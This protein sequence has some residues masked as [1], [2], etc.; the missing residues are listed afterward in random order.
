MRIFY[1]LLCLGS[2]VAFA[3]GSILLPLL[4]F[5]LAWVCLLPERFHTFQFTTCCTRVC[6]FVLVGPHFTPDSALSLPA[7]FLSCLLAHHIRFGTRFCRVPLPFSRCC[8][9]SVFTSRGIFLPPAALLFIHFG[10]FVYLLLLR[11]LYAFVAF[12]PHIL[13]RVHSA[14]TR[15]LRFLPAAVAPVAASFPAHLWVL[16]PLRLLRV[17]PSAS[18]QLPLSAAT[19]AHLVHCLPC[20][21]GLPCLAYLLI[22]AL[23]LPAILQ[24]HPVF[25]IPCSACTFLSY[26]SAWDF[27]PPFVSLGSDAS[28][29]CF[30][31]RLFAFSLWFRALFGFASAT[32]P[33][34]PSGFILLRDVRGLFTLSS[35]LPALR[36]RRYPPPNA[37]TL[38]LTHMPAFIAFS[39]GLLFNAL[40][41]RGSP[42]Y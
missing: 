29:I 19:H 3:L 35:C 23:P 16:P 17:L 30:V 7:G 5:F 9:H 18:R 8:R 42:A 40:V 21:T 11:I 14:W 2:A 20:Y 6:R 25:T 28:R 27:S 12:L 37:R 1:H 22:P 34:A 39:A 33:S 26:T 32:L 41:L 24:I 36:L 31:Y 10:L 4:F 15:H 13:L 38:L